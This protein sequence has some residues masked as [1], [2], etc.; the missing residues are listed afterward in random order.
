AV[1]V[2]GGGGITLAADDVEINST[3]VFS[4][5]SGSTT[6]APLTANRP[7]SL[8]TETG[9][10]LSLTDAE[11]DR[12]TAGAINIGDANSG[13]ITISAALDRAAGSTTAINLTTG[14]NN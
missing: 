8:G 2:S 6:I 11:L 10:Q 14:G 3:A 4:S 5:A 12:I 9:G 7:I 13:A 1:S